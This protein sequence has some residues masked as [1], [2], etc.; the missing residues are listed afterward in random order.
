MP[1]PFRILNIFRYQNFFEAEK[2]SYTK[3]VGTV[4]QS[5]WTHNRDNSPLLYP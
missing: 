4:K 2:G 1:A 5:I 3:Y